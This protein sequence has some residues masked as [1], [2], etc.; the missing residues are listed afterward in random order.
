LGRV[1]RGRRARPAGARRGLRAR[2]LTRPGPRRDLTADLERVTARGTAL[3]FVFSRF[4]PGYGLLMSTA[5]QAARRLVQAGQATVSVVD[6]ANHTFDRRGPREQMITSLVD[7]LTGRYRPLAERRRGGAPFFDAGQSS[8][9]LSLR[10]RAHSA[11][12]TDGRPRL[13][14]PQRPGSHDRGPRAR[15]TPH[16]LSPLARRRSG[17]SE[18]ALRTGRLRRMY[19][20]PLGLGRKDEE[21]RAPRD[22]LLPAPGLRA[23]RARR[24]DRRRH[25]SGEE[26]RPGIPAALADRLPRRRAVPAAGHAGDRRGHRGRRCEARVRTEGGGT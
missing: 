16:R 18:E 23:R 5:G 2:S 12:E 15:L 14:L 26:T 10:G 8:A 19:G 24:H 9:T 4:D 11:G 6:G 13:L 3:T 7:H 25:R 22:Q 20:D 17:G 1:D 21:A